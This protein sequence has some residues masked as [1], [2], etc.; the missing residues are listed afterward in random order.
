VVL[1]VVSATLKITPSVEGETY[2]RCFLVV[3]LATGCRSVK[4]TFRR[5]DPVVFAG[6]DDGATRATGDEEPPEHAA[7]TESAIAAP[8]RRDALTI[9]PR[10]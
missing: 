6:E 10:R 3:V 4:T 9:A 8:T 2:E 1:V 5:C 7:R